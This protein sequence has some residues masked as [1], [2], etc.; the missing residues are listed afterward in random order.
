MRHVIE[1]IQISMWCRL[2]IFDEGAP[3]LWQGANRFDLSTD[4]LP[5][6]LS[7]YEATRLKYALENIR[8]QKV[9]TNH[10]RP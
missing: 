1:R 2:I 5:R 3:V 9:S 4:E 8:E 6:D 7:N 10:V